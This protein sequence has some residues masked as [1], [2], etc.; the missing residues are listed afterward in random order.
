MWVKVYEYYTIFPNKKIGQTELTLHNLYHLN[1][2]DS[3]ILVAKKQFSY[4]FLSDSSYITKHNSSSILDVEIHFSL[5]DGSNK[6]K[7]SGLTSDE[8]E[9]GSLY[10]ENLVTES[11]VF[12]ASLEHQTNLGAK[13]IELDT[14]LL[15]EK[16]ES[17]TEKRILTESETDAINE[18]KKGRTNISSDSFDLFLQNESTNTKSEKDFKSIIDNDD[19]DNAI[20]DLYYE[21]NNVKIIYKVAKNIAKYVMF[22]L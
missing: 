12:D 19:K 7:D 8:K 6:I 5:K 3:K 18:I 4:L 13:K 20:A 15:S 9:M 17:K 2:L 1:G 21:Y 16:N 11:T 10:L 14:S 22:T